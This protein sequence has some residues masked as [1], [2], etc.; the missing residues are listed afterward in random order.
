MT[1]CHGIGSTASWRSQ[2]DCDVA[3]TLANPCRW[4]G[5]VAAAS[6]HSQHASKPRALPA[7]LLQPRPAAAPC[8]LHHRRHQRQRCTARSAPRQRAPWQRCVLHCFCP[9]AGIAAINSQM[10]VFPDCPCPVLANSV[11][12]RPCLSLPCHCMQDSQVLFV[13]HWRGRPWRSQRR[14]LRPGWPRRDL[15]SCPAPYRPSRGR[16]PRRGHPQ[17]WARSCPATS[18]NGWPSRWD[19][20]CHHVPARAH[21]GPRDFLAA[22]ILYATCSAWVTRP[23]PLTCIVDC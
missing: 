11:V 20:P 13:H 16:T 18:S 22:R 21:M 4:H 14:S 3:D 2:A 12:S 5:G 17:R 9:Q 23:Y 19:A 8:L 7:V 6:L 10:S 1:K 15:Q